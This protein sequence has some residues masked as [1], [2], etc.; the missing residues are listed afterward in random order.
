ML[1]M[2]LYFGGS[3]TSCYSDEFHLEGQ[4]ECLKYVLHFSSCVNYSIGFIFR[5]SFGVPTL[6][7][8]VSML[9]TY[10]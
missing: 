3:V 4:D 6:W 7:P 9:D 8:N 10:T 1:D 5:S 2:R